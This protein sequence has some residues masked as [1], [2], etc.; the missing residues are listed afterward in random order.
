MELKRPQ[1]KTKEKK[2]VKNTT[3]KESKKRNNKKYIFIYIKRGLKCLQLT[4]FL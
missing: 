2:Q 1:D 3:N 4:T